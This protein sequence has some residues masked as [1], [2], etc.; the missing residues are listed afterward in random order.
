MQPGPA[1]VGGALVGIL[2]GGLVGYAIPDRQV[3]PANP[4]VLEAVLPGGGGAGLCVGLL[5]AGGGFIV[6]VLAALWCGR[7][8][9]QSGPQRGQCERAVAS[10]ANARAFAPGLRTAAA[11]PPLASHPVGVERATSLPGRRR[12]VN[13]SLA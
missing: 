4:T 6:G 3:E 7:G 5:L 12:R 13:L 8:R 10:A 11:G 1:A 9:A 2:G